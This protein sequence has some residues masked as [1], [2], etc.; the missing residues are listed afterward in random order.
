MNGWLVS[1]YFLISSSTIGLARFVFLFFLLMFGI[2]FVVGGNQ[3]FGAVASSKFGE[4]DWLLL[5]E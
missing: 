4:I 2:L 5:G 1:N 3:L